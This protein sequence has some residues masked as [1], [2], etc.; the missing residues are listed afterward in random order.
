MSQASECTAHSAS[1]SLR[2]MPATGGQAEMLDGCRLLRRLSD[3]PLLLLIL[4]LLLLRRSPAKD[5][6]RQPRA[7][8]PHRHPPLRLTAACKVDA[9]HRL[10]QLRRHLLYRQLHRPVAI[11]VACSR[12]KQSKWFEFAG[13]VP[14]PQAGAP[15]AGLAPPKAAVR[16]LC[17]LYAGCTPNELYWGP[18]GLS[19]APVPIIGPPPSAR[20]P[21]RHK[22][23]LS[24]LHKSYSCLASARGH[25]N[26]AA[27]CH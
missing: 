24:G 18:A 4:H 27:S 20:S 11:G 6:G 7:P 12:H 9:Q 22:V 13:V 3:A 25:R 10:W 23:S 2:S 5:R 1:Q 8:L 21:Y 26:G 17:R 16:V 14:R 19:A 15:R